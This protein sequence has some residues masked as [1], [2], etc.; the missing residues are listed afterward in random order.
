MK[1]SERAEAGREFLPARR[2]ALSLEGLGDGRKFSRVEITS[3][4]LKNR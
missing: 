4:G 2:E 3:A 1:I